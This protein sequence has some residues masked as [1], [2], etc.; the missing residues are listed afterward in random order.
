MTALPGYSA[1]AEE[2]RL[3]PAIALVGDKAIPDDVHEAAKTVGVWGKGHERD[4]RVRYYRAIMHL[5]DNQ[6]N[7]AERELKAALTE[8]VILKSFFKRDLEAAPV[9][10]AG[11]GG[12]VPE[13]LAK[14]GVCGPR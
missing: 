14:M 9:C 4:P 11:P 6:P 7:D 3:D 13:R 12:G 8:K 2:A 10:N 1:R 5:D